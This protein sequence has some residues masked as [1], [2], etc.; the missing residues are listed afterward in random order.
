MPIVTMA[1]V[2][3]P[4]LLPSWRQ[5]SSS[6]LTSSGV[7]NL[8]VSKSLVGA[9]S[10]LQGGSSVQQC[11]SHMLRGAPDLAQAVPHL[12]RAALV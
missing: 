2:C 4:S 11:I 8:D 6:C 12:C 3:R 10:T 1:A 7:K 5:C 9:S